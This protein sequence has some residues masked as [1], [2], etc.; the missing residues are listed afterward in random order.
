[1][2]ITRELSKISESQR[3]KMVKTPFRECIIYCAIYL[4]FSAVD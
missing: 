4:S 2:E 3:V 1:M